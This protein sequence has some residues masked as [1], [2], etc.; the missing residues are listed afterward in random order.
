[1]ANNPERALDIWPSDE[2]WRDALWSGQRIEGDRPALDAYAEYLGAALPEYVQV[3]PYTRHLDDGFTI[4]SAKPPERED[5]PF[6]IAV[7]VTKADEIQINTGLAHALYHDTALNEGAQGRLIWHER[8]ISILGLSLFGG[9][10]VII[11]GAAAESD[12]TARTGAVIAAATILGGLANSIYKDRQD[13]NVPP[14]PD[15]LRPPI[16][17]VNPMSESAA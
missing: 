1:M 4:K 15:N 13:K 5:K 16:R 10:G 9:L 8:R 6:N 14:I 7:P 2:I 3:S 17:V 12:G 11:I